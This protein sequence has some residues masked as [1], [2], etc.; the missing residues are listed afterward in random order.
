[1]WPYLYVKML[2]VLGIYDCLQEKAL[3]DWFPCGKY[4]N[5]SRSV[6]NSIWDIFHLL[7]HTLEMR[8]K[9][10]QKRADN[11]QRSWVP[12]PKLNLFLS[13]ETGAAGQW[14]FLN[15]HVGS[16]CLLFS[17]NFSAAWFQSSLVRSL[18]L[19]SI[20]LYWPWDW[21][22]NSVETEFNRD[23]TWNWQMSF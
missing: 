1:M 2:S 16:Y 13:K 9:E 22:G 11:E 21:I 17:F 20:S 18:K 19:S 15:T 5:S 12:S 14:Y 3:H 23:F 10:K 8:T 6:I 4:L 7:L